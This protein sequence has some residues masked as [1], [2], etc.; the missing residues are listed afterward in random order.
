M[1]QHLKDYQPRR[2]LH[3]LIN[4]L[5][6]SPR[7]AFSPS[8][9]VTQEKKVPDV[10]FYQAVI[11]WDVMRRQTDAVV[12]RGGQGTYSDIQFTRN[13]TVAK[14]V[15]MKRGIYHFY[16]DRYSPGA[17]AEKLFSLIRDDPPELEIWIDWENSYSGGFGS[18][19]NVVAM[20]ERIESLLP[21]SRVG[22]YTGYWF[23]LEHSNAITNAAQYKYLKERPLWL[24]WYSSNAALVRIPAPWAS[25]LMWQFGTPVW[26]DRYGVETAEIDMSFYNGT[27]AEFDARYSGV[28]L[29]PD[30]GDPMTQWYRVNTYKLQIR[31]GSGANY[32]DIGDLWQ[33]DRIQVD[34]PPLG[35]WLK[36][37]SILRVSGATEAP[38]P[39]VSAWCSAAYCIAVTPPVV[40]PP[41]P[42]ADELPGDVWIGTTRENV[43]LYRK[44]A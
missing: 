20:M 10:S 39:A 40:V 41:V 33:G 3:R 21:D 22:L 12:I 5:L 25:L 37:V 28:I 7:Y 14:R 31:A 42:T 38:P 44:V 36:I 29:P 27:Q 34:A 8:A 11:D 13:W 23:F 16:D 30:T 26:G 6:S 43:A 24:A 35:G 15:G 1:G 19:R 32:S 9:I 4:E 18:L 2:N 17:Q